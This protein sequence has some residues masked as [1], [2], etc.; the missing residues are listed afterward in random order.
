MDAIFIKQNISKLDTKL[1]STVD[2]FDRFTILSQL[3]GYQ[4]FTNAK[5][6]RIYLD[7]Q[8]II[9]EKIASV[10]YEVLYN[11]NVGFVENQHYNYFL[12]ET[13]YAKAIANIDTIDDIDYKIDVFLDYSATC[14]NIAKYEE[15]DLYIRKAGRLLEVYPNKL[16]EARLIVR[17]G[18]Q[19][20][21][22]SN[23]SKAIY[24]FLA[25]EDIFTQNE[26]ALSFKDFYFLTLIYS[27][28]GHVYSMTND[29]ERSIAAHAQ[30]V[31]LCEI[32]GIKTRI[33]FHYLN[34]GRVYMNYGDADNAENFFR[35][36]IATPDDISQNARAGALANLGKCLFNKEEYDDARKLYKKARSLYHSM[37]DNDFNNFS[38]IES[39]LA[40]LFLAMGKQGKAYKHLLEAYDYAKES[41]NLSQFAIVCKQISDFYAQKNNYKEAYKYQQL[42]NDIASSHAEELRSQKIF[43]LQTQFEAE[44]KDQE[45]ELLRLSATRLQHKALR[46]QMNPHFM[47]N[48]LNAIQKYINEANV[49][50][51]NFYLTKFA[52]LVRD[53]LNNSD[54]EIIS[55]ESE[56]DFLENYL[57]LNQKMRFEGKMKYEI[58]IDDEIEPDIFGVPSMIIQPFV[59]NALEHGVRALKNGLVQI[60]FEMFD[61]NNMLCIIQ[62]NGVG[63]ERAAEIKKKTQEANV[64][65]KHRSMGTL[66]T[67][68]RLAILHA[69][70]DIQD[71]VKTIDLKDKN[72]VPKGTRVEIIIPIL[73]VQR[74]LVV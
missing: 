11:V 46:A 57:L 28:L 45:A 48:V 65:S 36:A 4:N 58:N 54:E 19:F 6:V 66:I 61:D 31:N 29:I 53:S 3:I 26:D 42:H 8:K 2:T 59:E 41:Q 9:A 69:Y 43:E 21:Q 25:A 56:L 72:G 67:N 44:K 49:K 40:E 64:T 37:P 50:E 32:T 39:F 74:S 47:F 30:A 71:F 70:S 55:L 16:L 22:Q 18:F 15:A 51:A 27:G 38:I 7:E 60:F 62:D 1:Q 10:K 52:S 5:K 20:L 73:E 14:G 12:S 35:K 23:F 63:R 13:H 34:L 33:A 17:Q 68:D 24:L